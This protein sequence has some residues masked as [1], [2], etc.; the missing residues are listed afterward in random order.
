L[1]QEYGSKNCIAAVAVAAFDIQIKEFEF[2]CDDKEGPY[3]IR[4]FIEFGLSKGYITGFYCFENPKIH[5]GKIVE[6][7]DIEKSPALVIVKSSNYEGEQHAIYWDGEKVIDSDPAIQE[8]KLKEYKILG[9]FPI[10]KL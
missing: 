6:V 9:W 2:F 3:S 1:K 5:F 4:Q 10:L 7:Y 8:K